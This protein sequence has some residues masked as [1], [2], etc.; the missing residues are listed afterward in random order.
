MIPLRFFQRML[1]QRQ[2]S[3]EFA[4]CLLREPAGDNIVGAPEIEGEGY[5][6]G[7]M[8]LTGAHVER[9]G[10][11]LYVLW[12]TPTVFPDATIAARYGAVYD[13]RTGDV[14]VALD[15]GEVVESRNGPFTVVLPRDTFVVRV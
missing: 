1:E 5:P 13:R 11:K 3:G 10:R 8:L 14:A 4:L 7:G 12:D 15:F 2:T 6:P 9:E